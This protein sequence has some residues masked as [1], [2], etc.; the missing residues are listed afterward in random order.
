MS[1]VDI[2]SGT[3]DANA[4]LSCGGDSELALIGSLAA[5]GRFTVGG[6]R[7]RGVDLP[8]LAL[9]IAGLRQ[10]QD[11]TARFA[12]L[13][14]EPEGDTPFERFEGGFEIDHGMVSG[15]GLRLTAPSGGGEAEGTLD[16]PNR[17]LNLALHLRPEHQPPP[18]PLDILVTGGFDRPQR[19]LDSGA[20]QDHFRR[21][22]LSAPPP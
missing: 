19:T 16:L 6:G 4:T 13:Q 17:L 8:G 3:L 21:E 14:G 9:R 11:V 2:A 10:P 22:L 5:S 18:P 12:F 15:S 20:L 1:T 7:L